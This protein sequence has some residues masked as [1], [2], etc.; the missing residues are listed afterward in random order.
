MWTS[1]LAVVPKAL[2]LESH[3]QEFFHRVWKRSDRAVFGGA[4]GQRLFGNRL[5]DRLIPVQKIAK[6]AKGRLWRE[7]AGR[8]L[9]D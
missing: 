9:M 2:E 4:P 7:A 8:I 5:P 6:H 3:A 1:E